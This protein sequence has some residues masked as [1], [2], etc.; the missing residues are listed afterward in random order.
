MEKREKIIGIPEK[1]MRKDETV[2]NIVVSKVPLVDEKDEV[3]GILGVYEDITDK[4][5]M[6]KMIKE[7]EE[8]L[9]QQGRLAQMGEMIAMIAHQWRQPLATISATVS[10]LRVKVLTGVF[11]MEMYD[12][13]LE[14]ITKYTGYLSQT[15]D[16]FRS[17]FH[18][19][20]DSE[21][22]T[23][24]TIIEDVLKLTKAS[25]EQNSIRLEVRLEQE[26]PF[27]TYKNELTQVII[28]LIKNAQDVLQERSVENPLIIIH[29][30][31]KKALK[32]VEI[33]DNGGGILLDIKDKIF[34]PYFSTKRERDG[35]GLG[36][37]MS[38]T[39]TEEHCHGRLSFVNEKEGAK[40]VIEL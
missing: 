39:I 10:A 32:V 22:T 26:T 24:N 33:S 17:F 11:D 25:L 7:K 38:K 6:Q 16:D 23:F 40:F 27:E 36:L 3:I 4:I 1:Q 31:D 14:E 18:S 29:A 19:K 8:Q 5:M 2:A 15:I 20:K 9:L 34:D 13:K 12:S 21:V 35:T 30:Y 28:N 37:Y